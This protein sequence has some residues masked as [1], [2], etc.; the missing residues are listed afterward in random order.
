MREILFRGKRK[1][2]GEWVEGYLGQDTIIGN[3]KTWLGYVIK[4]IPKKLWDFGWFEIDPATIGQYTGLTDKN[5]KRIFE[6]DVYQY[7]DDEIQVVEWSEDFSR[8][9]LHSHGEHEVKNGRKMIK[10]KHDGWCDLDD[11]PLEE[12]EYLG[13]VHDN[14]ELIGD[15]RRKE[16]DSIC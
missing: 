9:M 8:I 13:N 6:G 16:G 3:G 2:N 14:P 4:P 11:Y 15:D 12:M 5:G 10:V 7:F 1:D